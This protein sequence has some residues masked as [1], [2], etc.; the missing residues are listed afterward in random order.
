MK[1]IWI[2]IEVFILLSLRINSF[3]QKGGLSVGI[4]TTES[5]MIGGFYDHHGNRFHLGITRQFSNSLGE[6]RIQTTSQL[7]NSPTGSGSFF[8][9]IDIG[10][11]RVLANRI[12]LYGEGSFG[13][14][15]S[16][17]NYSDIRY[18]TGGYHVVTG[19]KSMAGVGVGVGYKFKPGI[20][21]FFGIHQVRG[22][23]WGGRVTF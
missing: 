14:K 11:S 1:R 13:N 23:N 9:L 19:T 20:E 10:Y 15:K 17:L 8:Q 12:T 3:A 16:Y 21:A 6:A 7:A 4:G 22:F 5:L 18:T 2:V